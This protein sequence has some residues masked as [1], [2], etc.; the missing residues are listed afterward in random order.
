MRC[1]NAGGRCACLASRC[2]RQGKRN[3]SGELKSLRRSQRWRGRRVCLRVSCLRNRRQSFARRRPPGPPRGVRSRRGARIPECTGQGAARCAP[4]GA[5][6]K[7]FLSDI[8]KILAIRAQV[9][10]CVGATA[11]AEAVGFVAPSRRSDGLLLRQLGSDYQ[12]I[13]ASFASI[14]RCRRK[15]R[16]VTPPSARQCFSELR[17]SRKKFTPDIRFTA[18]I[19]SQ[20]PVLRQC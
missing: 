19:A 17:H 15:S 4:H 7:T 16:A 1:G 12:I 18:N 2:W 11:A 10:R 14:C 8:H 9:R 20:Q 6:G 5:T 13:P 3:G